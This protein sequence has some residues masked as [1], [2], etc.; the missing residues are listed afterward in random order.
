MR[1]AHC[2]FESWCGDFDRNLRRF[3]EGLERADAERAREAEQK[4]R[5]RVQLALAG[6]VVLVGIG[7]GIAAAVVQQDRAEKRQQAERL[8]AEKQ[9]VEDNLAAEA[10]RQS[11]LRAVRAG[12]LVDALSTAE[13][14]SVPRVVKDLKD[15][16]DLTGA[17]RAGI[18][19][20]EALP[21]KGAA[22]DAHMGWARR[23][24][25][26]ALVSSGASSDGAAEHESAWAS[27][28]ELPSAWEKK[29]T[30]RRDAALS[31]LR[32][33]GNA[34]ALRSALSQ[35]SAARADAPN[36]AA[37]FILPSLLPMAA[38]FRSATAG[39]G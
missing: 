34:E 22:A 7:G 28:P 1:I 33:E 3:A 36:N 20:E 17:T 23:E 31:A 8:G 13:T 21:A 15:Y 11:D 38:G 5:R 26:E 30:T 4:K 6:F 14:V 10:K 19:L 16:G 24:A 9:R 35:A 32:G 27:L 2:Q 18:A 37:V 25:L 12:A 39:R 29:L